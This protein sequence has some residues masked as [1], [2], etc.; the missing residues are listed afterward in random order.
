M[1]PIT[2]IFYP[3]TL[4]SSSHSIFHYS[5][6]GVIGY[7]GRVLR[8]ASRHSTLARRRSTMSPLGSGPVQEGI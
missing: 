6:I 5:Y 2:P 7:K 1:I 3:Y 8:S 4:Y